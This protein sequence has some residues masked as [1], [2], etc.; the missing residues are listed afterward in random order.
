MDHA[1]DDDLDNLIPVPVPALVTLLAQ[2]EED[3]GRALNEDE[4]LAIRDNAACIMMPLSA[5]AQLT[6]SRGYADIDPENVWQQWQAVRET[7]FD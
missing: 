3:K 5:I 4:V 2:H 6:A 1:I 7:L